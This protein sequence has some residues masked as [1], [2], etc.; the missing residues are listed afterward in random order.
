[1]DGGMGDSWGICLDAARRDGFKRFFIVRMQPKG[2]RKKPLGGCAQVAFRAAFR[3]HPLVAERTICRPGPYNALC[4]EIERLE[5]EGAAYVFY[6]REMPVDN[7]ETNWE[8]LN[9]S[10]EMGYAQAR[11]E[12]PLW[13]T[14]LKS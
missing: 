11:E 9:A 13:E 8:K 5:A 12:L 3:A 4:D 1:M 7:K 14:W 6:P 2:Y 10:F